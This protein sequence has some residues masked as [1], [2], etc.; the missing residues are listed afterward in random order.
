MVPGYDD[1]DR[2]RR[3]RYYHRQQAAKE[4][5]AEVE[6]APAPLTP[7]DRMLTLRREGMAY[8]SIACIL[9]L[10]WGIHVAVD[11]VRYCCHNRLC[12]TTPPRESRRGRPAHRWAPVGDLS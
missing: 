3:T 7:L 6:R 4:E 12:P 8:S 9:R 2:A 1:D 10:D 5:V 11:R